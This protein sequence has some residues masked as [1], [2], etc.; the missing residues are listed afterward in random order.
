M[1]RIVTRFGL[2]SGL[3][4]S[5]W[6]VGG[7]ALCYAKNSFEGSMWLGYA[8]MVLA[9]SLI[10][11]AVKSYRDKDNGGYIS[12]GKAFKIGLYISLIASTLYVV[13]WLIDYYI[14][15]PDFMDKFS[16]HTLSQLKADGLNEAELAEQTAEITKMQEMYKNPVF[17]VL[18]TYV[19]IL[20]V[21]LV[22]SLI[23]ALFLKRK[24]TQ[25]LQ[26]A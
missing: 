22:V 20:P 21:G 2:I 6:V 23:T 17:V 15:V 16:A 1:K 19:E 7:V 3:I 5:A 9:F 18:F 14:F 8:S 12:F 13:T 10:F 24:P 25:V 26:A 4:V 11:V